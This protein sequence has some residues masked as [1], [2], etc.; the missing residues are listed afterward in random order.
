MKLT[1]STKPFIAELKALLP[2]VAS[3]PGLPMLSG[4]RLDASGEGVALEATDLELTARR[5]VHD[6][7]TVDAAG[8]VVAPAKAL[9][10]VFTAMTEPKIELESDPTEARADVRVQAGT[11][12]VTLQGWAAEDWPAVA[13]LAGVDPIASVEASA[14]ADALERT[15]LCASRDES[16]PVLTC[17]ALEFREDPP[18]L[19]VV[20]TDSYRLGTTKVP[21]GSP[22]RGPGMPLL[23]PARAVRLLVKQLKAA[24]G[25][26]QIVALAGPGE[27]PSPDRVGFVVHDA[28]W[29]VRTIDDEFPNWRQVVPEPDGGSFEFE[30]E[31]L[32]AA[33]RAAASVR[34]TTGAPIRL[35]LDRTCSL[36]LKEPDLGEMREQLTEARFTPNGAGALE[37]AFN[38]DYL[39]DAIRFCGAERGQMWVRDGLKPVLFEALDRRYVLMPVRM[40]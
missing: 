36:A 37:V 33:L 26:V 19:E 13:R 16:R 29:T 14:V 31:E 20:A 8:S 27:D 6:E 30:P 22:I 11:R 12:T 7:V 17:V 21:V 2:A 10:K 3:R 23:I 38:P 24:E 15:A 34:S 40:P 18:S 28:E 5:V 35:S 1:L 39:A 25:A 4:V 32:T 9:V